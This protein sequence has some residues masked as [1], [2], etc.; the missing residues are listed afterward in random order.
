MFRTARAS[1]RLGLSRFRNRQF[2]EATM[3]AAALVATADGEVT[4]SEMSALDDLLE[5]VRDLNI[6]DPHVAVDLY[7]DFADAIGKNGEAAKRDALGTVAKIAGDHD[8][9]DLLIRV[10]V[11]ISKADGDLSPPEARAI[12]D[13]CGVLG[14]PV[15][16]DPPAAR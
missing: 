16:K 7:R 11:A 1:L 15:P 6:Y 13:L 3:A 12:S 2:L 4:F 8:A 9:C 5:T 10:A 14:V